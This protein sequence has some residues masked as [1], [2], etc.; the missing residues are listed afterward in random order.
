[1]IY[2]SNAVYR[3]GVGGF[4]LIHLFPKW[5]FDFFHLHHRLAEGMSIHFFVMWIFAINGTLYACYLMI[6]GEWRELYPKFK[7]YK[8]ALFVMLHDLG[9]KKELPPQGKFNAA[10]RIAYTAV[11]FM[12][13]G[14]LLTGL[15]IYKPIQISFLTAALG[16]YEW[17][18]FEHFWLTLGFVGFFV[19]HIA[20]VIRAGFNNFRAMVGGHELPPV[21]ADASGS[22]SVQ[23][24]IWE[25]RIKTRRSFVTG[26]ATTLIGLGSWSWMRSRRGDQGLAWPFRRILEFNENLWR[27]IFSPERTSQGQTPPILGTEA[28]INGDIGLASELQ[29]DYR[30][31]VLQLGAPDQSVSSIMEADPLLLV[32]IEEIKKLPKSEAVVDFKCIEGWSDIISYA[33][34]SFKDFCAHYKLDTD[35][36]Y[37]GLETPDSEYYVSIDMASMLHPQTMLVY[38]INGRPIREENGAPLRLIIPVKYGIKNL[39][40]VGT[41]KLANYRLPDYW[42]ERGYDWYA[43]L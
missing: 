5:F 16:G 2:W 41:I 10:Q 18:R 40:R 43:G 20:Q 17:A 19:I 12:G 22:A 36:E 35:Y 14:S 8:E 24:E 39:K 26:F 38:E 15:A 34:V 28:R 4:T 31:K 3:I 23:E 21:S 30:V 42:G 9:L 33:G 29:N 7:S 37:V 32:S 27:D 6:T 25:I 11:D 1:M 13:L